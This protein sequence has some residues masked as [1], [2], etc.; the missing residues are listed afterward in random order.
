M[1][2]R[3]WVQM[4]SMGGKF[5]KESK[6]CVFGLCEAVR[7]TTCVICR[8]QVEKGEPMAY[9][10]AIRRTICVECAEKELAGALE[11]VAAAVKGGTKWVEYQKLLKEV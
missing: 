4:M 6:Y 1:S 9:F 10:W 2:D 8:R 5:A 7:K 11:H 3:V